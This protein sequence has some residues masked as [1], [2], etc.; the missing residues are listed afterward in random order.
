MRA[1]IPPV[2]IVQAAQVQ[3]R[4]LLQADVGTN[5]AEMKAWIWITVITGRDLGSAMSAT[6]QKTPDQV[7]APPAMRQHQHILWK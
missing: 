7:A 6:C 2:A 1:G 5:H 3:P 4:L